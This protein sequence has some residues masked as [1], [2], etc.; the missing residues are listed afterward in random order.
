DKHPENR[1]PSFAAN[2]NRALPPN[3]LRPFQ[4]YG[5]I[6]LF[7]FG[8]TASYNSFQMGLNRRMS[9]GVMFGAAYTFSKT[10]GAAAS[11]TSTVSPFL[12][13]RQRN[14]GLLGYDRSHVLALH[15]NWAL[16]KLGRRYRL[17]PLTTVTD[18][19]EVAGISRF[20]SGAPFTPGF[21]T[22]DGQDITGTP[23]E[24]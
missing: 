12:P 16:P 9:H 5:D 15:Y 11:D 18:G 24:G 1:D 4:G 7:E 19:W 23:S 21:A 20:T 17:R 22:V 2:I 10:L 13:P 6:Y 8:S 14:Y 3:F